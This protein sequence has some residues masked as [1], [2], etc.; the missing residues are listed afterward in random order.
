MGT[1]GRWNAEPK[2]KIADL[3]SKS[4]SRNGD[5]GARISDN[6]ERCGEEW[7]RFGAWKVRSL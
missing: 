5:A 1:P 7:V 2:N 6:R 4:K 3:E